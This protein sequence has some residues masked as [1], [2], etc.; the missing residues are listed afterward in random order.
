MITEI[1]RCPAITALSDDADKQCRPGGLRH[2]SLFAAGV[3]WLAA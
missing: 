1:A 2:L 3:I